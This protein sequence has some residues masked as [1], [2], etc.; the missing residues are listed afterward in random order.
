MKQAFAKEIIACPPRDRTLFH[1]QANGYALQLL[2]Y[3]VGQGRAISE[4]KQSPLAH[5]LRKPEIKKRLAN[6][7]NGTLSSHDLWPDFSEPLFPFVLSLSTW[8]NDRG[9]HWHQTTRPGVNLVLQ[10]NFSNKHEKDY[11]QLLQVEQDNLFNSTGHP[12]TL[13][14]GF[15]FFRH[16][17]AWSRIDLSLETGEALIEEIQSDWCREVIEL[18]KDIQEDADFLD[19]WGIDAPVD[20][21]KQYIEGVMKPYLKLWDEAMLSAAITFIV[22]ELGLYT[23]YYHSFETGCK[24]KNIHYNH[25]PR[26]LYTKLPRKFG[27]RETDKAPVFIRQD[28]NA[29]RKL[30]K[31]KDAK[32][33]VMQFNA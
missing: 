4:L 28:K 24:V 17:L 22:E 1:Y 14:N 3:H 27:F 9:R 29:R 33:F 10:L 21:V 5:L 30:K 16:T 2:K 32:W 11:R 13:A 25:P 18:H 23:L 7:G 15:A 31:V 6:R 20:K 12:V 19:Y 8:G 26:S